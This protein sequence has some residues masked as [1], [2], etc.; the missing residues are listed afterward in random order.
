MGNV[1]RISEIILKPKKYDF[2]IDPGWVNYYDDDDNHHQ[3]KLVNIDV[4]KFDRLWAENPNYYIGKG[5]TGQIKDRYQKFGQFLKTIDQP[6]H[7]ATVGINEY[8]VSFYNGRH[9][10]SWFRDNGYKT[11]PVAMDLD[12]IKFAK[13]LGL[14]V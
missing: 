3:R 6:V 14:L 13:Q 2:I 11:I 12:S 1:M 10:Y 4:K 7:A 8:G 5:G 9:R